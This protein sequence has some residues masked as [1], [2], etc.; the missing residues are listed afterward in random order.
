[1]GH[2]FYT[3][4]SGAKTVTLV[5]PSEWPFV[6]LYPWLH[7]SYHQ[8]QVHHP[9]NLSSSAQMF[10]SYQEVQNVSVTL[11]KGDALY[12]PPYWMHRVETL[13]GAVDASTEEEAAADLDEIAVAISVVSPSRDE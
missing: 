7:P 9:Q 10:P 3:V 11:R 8:S 6:Y 12:I 13:G 4:V 2:N 1:M 5:P